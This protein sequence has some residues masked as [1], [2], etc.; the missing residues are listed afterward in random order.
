MNQ[1]SE[2]ACMP[3]SARRTDPVRTDRIGAPFG[4]LVAISLDRMGQPVLGVLG[5]HDAQVAKHPLAHNLAR[6]PHHRMAGVV[7]GDRQ[8]QTRRAG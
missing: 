4:L 3:T 2:C 1:A 5:P 8:D 7:Q 6:L